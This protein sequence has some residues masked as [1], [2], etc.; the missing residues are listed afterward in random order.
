MR[1]TFDRFSE[2]NFPINLELVS[3]L[4]SIAEKKG[5][6]ATKLALAWG[7]AQWKGIIPIPGSVRAFHL[8]CGPFMN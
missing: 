1:L 6:S 3:K 8:R 7:L 4:Q 5:V 2:E